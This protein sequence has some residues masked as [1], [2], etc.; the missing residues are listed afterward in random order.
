[1]ACSSLVQGKMI[2]LVLLGVLLGVPGGATC[3]SRAC[4]EGW[5]TS[6]TASSRR[7]GSVC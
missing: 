6:G 1:M 5:E 4:A 3:M 2:G 7:E